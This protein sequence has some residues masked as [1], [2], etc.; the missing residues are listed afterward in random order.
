[1]PSEI[2]SLIDKIK[3]VDDSDVKGLFMLGVNALDNPSQKPIVTSSLQKI[4]NRIKKRDYPNRNQLLDL[5]IEFSVYIFES[6]SENY[7]YLQKLCEFYALKKGYE[8]KIISNIKDY[9]ERVNPETLDQNTIDFLTITLASAYASKGDNSRAISELEAINSSSTKVLDNLA[10]FYYYDRKPQKAIDLL[11]NESNLNEPMAFWLSKSYHAIGK[12]QNALNILSPFKNSDRV[13]KFINQLSV[14]LRKSSGNNIP[15]N[16]IVV[17][18][19]YSFNEKDKDLVSGFI[20]LLNSHNFQVVTGEK[21]SI[22]SLSKSIIGKIRH[23]SIFVVVMTKRD[24]KENNKFTTSSWLLEEKGVAVALDKP[25][26][27]LVE[28]E[29]DEKEIGGIQGDDQR[30]SFSRNN[31]VSKVVEAIRMIQE[32]VAPKKI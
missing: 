10:R 7:F 24:R 27:M 8:D 16:K 31:F 9:F 14:S 21:N 2:K 30:L 26:L 1:M 23:S 28:D 15:Q 32:H 4:K 6:D 11:E 5:S 19:S 29:I 17:F 3:N 12:T 20:D 18:L 13:K 25:C 22:G